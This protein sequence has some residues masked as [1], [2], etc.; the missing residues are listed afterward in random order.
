MTL[1]TARILRE[2]LTDPS[3]PRYGYDLMRATGFPSG[4]L[5]PALGK[6]VQAGL[7]LR[8]KEQI[9]PAVEGRPARRIYRL[10]DSGIET[11]RYELAVLSQQLTPP[12]ARPA[13][14][15][16]EWGRA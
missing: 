9:D 1:T 3:Q 11:A 7:L 4:K 15:R 8:E 14:L 13:R 10:S 12:A 2:F 16:T 5:Y 6:L